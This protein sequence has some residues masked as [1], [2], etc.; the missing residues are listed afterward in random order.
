M[1]SVVLLSGLLCSA[2]IQ[3]LV[4]N[5]VTPNH[6]RSLNTTELVCIILLYRG[7]IEVLSAL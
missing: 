4:E 2:I 3:Y 1:N 5:A 6:H 7:C